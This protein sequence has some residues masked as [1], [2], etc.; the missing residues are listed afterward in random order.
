M[1]EKPNRFIKNEEPLDDNGF[2]SSS[3][4]NR[5]DNFDNSING[6][7]KNDQSD[8]LNL[9][10]GKQFNAGR[11]SL[12]VKPKELEKNIESIDKNSVNTDNSVKKA[13]VNMPKSVVNK[14]TSALPPGLKHGVRL[15]NRLIGRKAE[16]KAAEQQALQEEIMQQRIDQELNGDQVEDTTSQ[17]GKGLKAGLKNKLNPLGNKKEEADA[18]MNTTPSIFK[19]MFGLLTGF[20][21]IVA[22]FLASLPI[23]LPLA[24]LV[25][26]VGVIVAPIS[27]VVGAIKGALENLGQSFSNLW[28]YGTFSTNATLIEE[29]EEKV[30]K[31][32][33]IFP[34]IDTESLKGAL[35]YGFY[36]FDEFLD[37]VENEDSDDIEDFE[38]KHKFNYKKL[39]LYTFTVANQLIYSTVTFDNNLIQEKEEIEEEKEDEKG[40][41]RII[42]RTKFTYRC[43]AGSSMINIPEK[44]DL[45]VNNIGTVEVPIYGKT[46]KTE[47]ADYCLNLVSDANIEYFK[48][49]DKNF[50]KN[51]KCVSV[52]YE[53]GT[54]RSIEKYENFLKYV[55]IPENYFDQSLDSDYSYKWDKF[56]SKFSDDTSGIFSSLFD[57][58]GYNI[59]AHAI[60]EGKL[61][62]YSNLSETEKLEANRAVSSLLSLIKAVKDEDNISGKYHIAGAVSLPLD[63]TMKDTA[64][65]TIKS[66]ITSGFGPRKVK[67]AGMSAYHEAIDFSQKNSSG[68]KVYAFLDGVVLN[69]YPITSSC[70]LGVYLGHDLDGD[71]KYDYYTRYCHMRTRYVY[72]GSVVNNGQ[73]I[74]LTGSTGVATGPHLHFEIHDSNK[75]KL[76][77]LQYLIDAVKN[78][79]TLTSVTKELTDEKI[80]ELTTTYEN[81]MYGSSYT[82]EGVVITA[83]FLVDN[84]PG[85][86]NFCEGYTT[87]FIDSNWYK[88]K[89]I[90]GSCVN[91][92][93][94]SKYGLSNVG[95]I[96]WAFN[97]AGFSVTKRYSLNELKNL[98]ERKNIYDSDVQTGDI[99]YDGNNIGIIIQLNDEKAV[100]AYVGDKGL[101]TQTITRKLA[102]SPFRYAVSLNNFYGG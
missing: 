94:T 44:D 32:E 62:L 36:S 26:V 56:I 59:P 25:V 69:A 18:N 65:E 89:T 98:G 97:Q 42:K 100:I 45:C 40:K 87:S 29:F 60:G 77:P 3:N 67:T 57:R 80:Q 101:T 82:R 1:D 50:N 64:E 43:P 79:S 38:A 13:P 2:S 6:K 93:S 66:R 51:L 70:G 15:G 88:D 14:A 76:N 4:P 102:S 9:N 74:G 22:G 55:M 52:A 58:T 73:V 86:P 68:D 46:K 54:E 33:E 71:G 16:K 49:E 7:L 75:K 41:K 96:N 19:K 10:T 95:F 84:L 48:Q 47:T 23:V 17:G 72:Q 28:N 34:D 12:G 92:G 81:M 24:I 61:D 5:I 99:A 35:Y 20:W 83:K 8:Q 21:S 91:K 27:E 78:Q 63:F 31:V 90:V 53:T 11:G 39:K 30:K 85:L 37:E